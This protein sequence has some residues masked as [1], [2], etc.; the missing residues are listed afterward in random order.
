MPGETRKE[1]GSVSPKATTA[2]RPASRSQP[3]TAPPDSFGEW[4]RAFSRR[5]RGNGR[6]L[7]SSLSRMQQW[8]FSWGLVL[9]ALAAVSFGL[10]VWKA[11]FA[12]AVEVM[13]GKSPL[14]VSG[15]WWNVPLGIAS[16][17]AV[18][19]LTGAL[20]AYLVERR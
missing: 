20:V 18:P 7:W 11:G 4:R 8:L 12:N 3:L 19:A 16:W 13:L 2:V 15:R 6:R 5:M 1:T 10:S 14:E 9:A 17:L